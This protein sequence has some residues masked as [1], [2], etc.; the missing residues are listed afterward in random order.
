MG[1]A[2]FQFGYLALALA[3]VLFLAGGLNYL[4]DPLW[5]AQGNRLDGRN[6]AFNERVSKI[7]LL[8]RTAATAEYDCL[9]LGSSRGT[10]LRPSQISGKRCFNLALKGAAIA[11]SIAYARYAVGQ[12]LKLTTL[13]VGVDDFAFLAG[14]VDVA[15]RS[16]PR[17]Q[18]SDNFFHAFF[19]ADVLTFSA[20]TVAGISPDPNVYYDRHYE[21]V[22]LPGKRYATPP[23]VNKRDKACSFDKVALYHAVREVAPAAQIVGYVPPMAPEYRLSD[24][25]SR[26]VLDCGAEAFHRVAQGYDGFLDF[27][28]PSPTTVA[29]DA[30]YDGSHFSPAA[31]D[32][33]AA[34]LA[35]KRTD[36]AVDVKAL[37][38]EAYQQTVRERLRGYLHT[39][40]QDEAWDRLAAPDD[41]STPP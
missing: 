32:Q 19:S 18:G 21:A 40:G 9:I 24:V 27:A 22:E 10:S 12:G 35:G 28:V 2:R 23:L 8:R 25:Y 1:E 26:K 29:A 14:G 33:V 38:L 39:K 30:S 13:F 11:E 36:L 37:S 4:I 20:M 5:Y 16:K 7:N 34:Q 17:I 15:A 31:N 41:E 6:F 3:V